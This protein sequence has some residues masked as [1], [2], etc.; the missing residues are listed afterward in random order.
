[1]SIDRGAVAQLVRVPD[2]RSGGCGFE[3]R[4]RRLLKPQETPRFPGFFRAVVGT[5]ALNAASYRQLQQCPIRRNSK[6][7][8]AS[9]RIVGVPRSVVQ[10]DIGGRDE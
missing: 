8:A 4:Q 3:P 1:M 7:P 6:V 2:C 5:L 9:G 10:V